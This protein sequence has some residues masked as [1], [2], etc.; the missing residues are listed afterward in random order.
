LKSFIDS[1]GALGEITSID[2]A[3]WADAFGVIGNF[4]SGRSIGRYC[5]YGAL[6]QPPSCTFTRVQF[7]GTP[8]QQQIGVFPPCKPDGQATI[9]ATLVAD[10]SCP[11]SGTKVLLCYDGFDPND[12]TRCTSRFSDVEGETVFFECAVECR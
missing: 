9:C 7:W 10:A 11:I 5:I 1:Y 3:S 6:S 12:L 8:M 2:Q 4:G